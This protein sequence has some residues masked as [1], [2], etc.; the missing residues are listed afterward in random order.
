VTFLQR[1]KNFSL[2]PEK[3]FNF[4]AFR[5]SAAVFLPD[6]LLNSEGGQEIVAV[7]V[8]KEGAA[9]FDPKIT[10]SSVISVTI[11]AKHFDQ[12]VEPVKIWFRRDVRKQPGNYFTSI[13]FL[14]QAHVNGSI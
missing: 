3:Q 9:L 10:T 11:G 4:S 6:I 7:V 1:V 2:F 14:N 5:F 13:F 12:L 8:F